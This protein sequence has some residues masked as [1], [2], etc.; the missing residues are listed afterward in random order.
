M[1]DKNKELLAGL[2][3]VGGFVLFFG[4][5]AAAYIWMMMQ[6]WEGMQ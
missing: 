4:A 2:A 6:T 1:S 3:V 5:V